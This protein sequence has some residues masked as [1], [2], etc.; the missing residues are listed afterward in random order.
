MNDA[1]TSLED[2]S[3]RVTRC[4]RRFTVVFREQLLARKP[5]GKF[6][7][8][9]F[10]PLHDQAVNRYAPELDSPYLAT[11]PGWNESCQHGTYTRADTSAASL[12]GEWESEAGA[13]SAALFITCPLRPAI[14]T[15]VPPHSPLGTLSPAV[16]LTYGQCGVL[17]YFCPMCRS[18]QYPLSLAAGVLGCYGSCLIRG[19]PDQRGVVSC[20]RKLWPGQAI[21]CCKSREE[22]LGSFTPFHVSELSSAPSENS[23]AILL[24]LSFRPWLNRIPTLSLKD[25]RPEGA[26]MLREREFSCI[27]TQSAIFSLSRT[28]ISKVTPQER[29]DVMLREERAPKSGSQLDIAMIFVCDFF[30]STNKWEYAI[31]TLASHQGEPGALPDRVTGFSLVGGFSRGSPISLAPS[32]RRRSI[33]TS[34][35]LIG[36]QDLG[37]RNLF[38]SLLLI[39]WLDYLS[40]TQANWVLFPAESLPDSRMWESCRTMSLVGE[41][42]RASL[43]CSVLAFRRRFILTPIHPNRPPRS[44]EDSSV[45]RYSSFGNTGIREW[46]GGSTGR[47]SPCWIPD[48]PLC[49]SSPIF[50]CGNRAEQCCWPVG[51]LE[52]LPFPPPFYS[53]IARYSPRFTLIGSQDLDVKSSQ[54]FLLHRLQSHRQTQHNYRLFTG[55]GGCSGGGRWEDQPSRG[56]SPRTRERVYIV[57]GSPSGRDPRTLPGR[58]ALRVAHVWVA[59]HSPR[60]RGWIASPDCGDTRT[61]CHVASEGLMAAQPPR[62]FTAATTTM[63]GETGV[64]RESSLQAASSS[65]IL[66]CEDPG[67]NPPVDRTRIALVGGKRASHCATAAPLNGR[68]AT[69]T[70]IE[71]GFHECSVDRERRIT[72]GERVVSRRVVQHANVQLPAGRRQVLVTR[73]KSAQWL[74]ACPGPRFRNFPMDH[75]LFRINDAAVKLSRRPPTFGHSPPFANYTVNKFEVKFPRIAAVLLTDSQCDTR[76]EDLPC[77]RH[78]GANPR[79]SHYRSATLPLSYESDGRGFAP[80]CLRHGRSSVR[81]SHCESVSRTAALELRPNYYHYNAYGWERVGKDRR[82]NQCN[83]PIWGSSKISARL[84]LASGNIVRL[85]ISSIWTDCV[86]ENSMQGKTVIRYRLAFSIALNGFGAVCAACTSLLNEVAVL[87][88]LILTCSGVYKVFR[89]V[90]AAV[91]FSMRSRIAWAPYQAG[92]RLCCALTT[93]HRNISPLHTSLPDLGVAALTAKHVQAVVDWHTSVFGTYLT[94]PH[95]RQA[96]HRRDP[97]SEESRI[98]TS[99]VAYITSGGLRRSCFILNSLFTHGKKRGERIRSSVMRDPKSSVER[100]GSSRLITRSDE[101]GRTSGHGSLLQLSSCTYRVL[102]LPTLSTPCPPLKSPTLALTVA[103]LSSSETVPIDVKGSI[104]GITC[105]FPVDEPS[106][107]TAMN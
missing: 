35:N 18:Q 94:G 4:R 59:S 24:P 104:V 39:N 75:F 37:R 5:R 74:G 43:T 30:S 16:L 7:M 99:Q 82:L 52:D 55:G 56:S 41:L 64:P 97:M 40:L 1:H 21:S 46:L 98:I 62:T 13:H 44:R 48:F 103:P 77:R 69:C 32:F 33:S 65:T 50:A 102:D 27:T 42:S 34:I 91:A 79:P 22:G 29:R 9:A 63:A 105:W 76:T 45:D 15:S 89:I 70:D 88:F 47:Q 57:P 100:T 58:A 71:H 10:K 38:T 90:D 93:S 73:L 66:T 51:L 11:L 3:E 78:R 86:L 19:E 54:I 101:S 92:R 85:K 6:S 20:C 28:L 83:G 12:A 23:G 60:G 87:M 72:A 25:S 106:R 81:V 36:S 26:K 61:L 95:I 31:S 14:L 49:H 107:Q 96:H 2:V 8:S 67:A 68:T 17:A 53:F 80:R 84:L